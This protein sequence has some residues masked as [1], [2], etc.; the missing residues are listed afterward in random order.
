[1]GTSDTHYTKSLDTINGY[2]KSAAQWHDP[3]IQ[4]NMEYEKDKC[5]I[6]FK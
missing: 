2:Y 4:D 1:M 5:I 3:M 6:Y